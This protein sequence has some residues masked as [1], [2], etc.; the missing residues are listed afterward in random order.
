MV[1]RVIMYGKSVAQENSIC[2]C[3]GVLVTIIEKEIKTQR[4]V[5]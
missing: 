5:T 3:M 1:V 4:D 2:T